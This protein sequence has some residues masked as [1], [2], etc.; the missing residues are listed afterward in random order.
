MDITTSFPSCE[1]MHDVDF[2]PYSGYIHV[3][4]KTLATQVD[5]LTLSCLSAEPSVLLPSGLPQLLRWL[6]TFNRESET[7][8][9]SCLKQPPPLNQLLRPLFSLPTLTSSQSTRTTSIKSIARTVNC[10]IHMSHPFLATSRDCLLV[11]TL[12]AMLR[13]FETRQSM[14]ERCST[15]NCLLATASRITKFPQ[16]RESCVSGTL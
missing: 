13:F 5:A 10:A 4:L 11:S 6:A 16:G 3:S 12:Q 9:S 7:E 1:E 14:G 8:L 15:S 2:L